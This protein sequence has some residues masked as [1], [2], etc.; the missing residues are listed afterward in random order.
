MCPHVHFDQ[1]DVPEIFELIMKLIKG[2][3][4]GC[5]YCRTERSIDF[6]IPPGD[7]SKSATVF[8]TRWEDLGD[9]PAGDCCSRHLGYGQLQS[10]IAFDA[11]ELSSGFKSIKQSRIESVTPKEKLKAMFRKAPRKMKRNAAREFKD[12]L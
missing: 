3:L 9:D 12:I 5:Q 10:P 4:V 7:G 8:F 2:F 6:K 11:G 1:H